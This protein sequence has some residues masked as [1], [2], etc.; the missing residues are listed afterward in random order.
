MLETVVSFMKHQ[1]DRM[2]DPMSLPEIQVVV[3]RAKE[4]GFK[5]GT[6]D[7]PFGLGNTITEAQRWVD[8]MEAE[9]MGVVWR[10]DDP[11]KHPM[12]NQPIFVGANALAPS[13][14]YG[15]AESLIKNNPNLFKD[16][17]EWAIYYES[18]TVWKGD[19]KEMN[20][21]D[22]SKSWLNSNTKENYAKF[23]IDLIDVCK[24][25]F[26]SINKNVEVGYHSVNGSEYLNK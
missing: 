9:G 20:F 26:T 25:S 10:M 4:V 6:I 24:G 1:Q 22:Q 15:R 21:W 16:G 19:S 2:N 14:Y 23:F 11:S 13:V 8:V 17:H 12:Y 18:T 5:K 7:V 3:K